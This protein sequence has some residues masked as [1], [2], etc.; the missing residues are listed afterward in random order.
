MEIKCEIGLLK[1][2]EKILNCLVK[3]S[4]SEIKK[5]ELVRDIYTE[6]LLEIG[7][8]IKDKEKTNDRHISW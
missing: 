1:Q 7:K 5:Y 2:R 8:E 4:I 3:N 6:E